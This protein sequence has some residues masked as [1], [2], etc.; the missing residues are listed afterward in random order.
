MNNLLNSFLLIWPVVAAIV[1]LS[2]SIFGGYIFDINEEIE[3]SIFGLFAFDYLIE[4]F[5]L[6]YICGFLSMALLIWMPLRDHS[7]YFPRHLDMKVY[8]DTNGI[9]KRRK[10][11][12]SHRSF[13]FEI[14]SDW[15]KRKTAFWKGIENEVLKKTKKKIKLSG[16]SSSSADGG[17]TFFVKK[18]PKPGQHYLI[19]ESSGAIKHKDV[20]ADS[21]LETLFELIDD[22]RAKFSIPIID[23]LWRFDFLLNP[24][25]NQIYRINPMQPVAYQIV[26]AV[27]CLRFF[28]LIVVGDSI[29]L[30]KEGEKFTPIA[31]C[32]YEY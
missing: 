2:F 31:Y 20:S 9:E 21:N 27:T 12:A 25:F 14:Y 15:E 32:I 11:L 8:S 23:M 10:K 1:L 6:R 29:Y 28:P 16:E 26:S 24:R 5:H 19:T 17:T 13:N 22:D 3:I 30:L 4:E 18:Q 7:K